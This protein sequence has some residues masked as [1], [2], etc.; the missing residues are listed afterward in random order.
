[1][2]RDVCMRVGVLSCFFLFGACFSQHTFAPGAVCVIIDPSPL[3]LMSTAISSGSSETCQQ[4]MPLKWRNNEV[5]QLYWYQTQI[6]PLQDCSTWLSR[7]P[8]KPGGRSRLRGLV[9]HLS[10]SVD[11]TVSSDFGLF[12]CI[13]L[14]QGHT[15]RST[16]HRD[17]HLGY[18][19]SWG[20]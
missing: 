3:A 20:H 1:M 17:W 10:A 16:D 4:S 18:M 7:R 13:L 8:F 6:P 2:P 12:S 9:C 19:D 15:V 5:H 11:P 14:E